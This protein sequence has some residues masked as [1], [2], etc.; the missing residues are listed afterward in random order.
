MRLTR[1]LATIALLAAASCETET[2]SMVVVDNDYP[3]VSDGGDATQEMTVFKVWWTTTLLPDPVAP[4]NE[5]EPERTVLN[6]DFAYAVVAPGWAPS[7]P[8][9]P[10]IFI[11][12]KSVG[13]L[14]VA[15]GDT[16]HIH[17]SDDLFVGNCAANKPLSQED[18][19]FISQ[20]IFPAEFAGATYDAK[21][22]TATPRTLRADAN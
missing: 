11:P 8:T 16:L 12:M 17:V 20:R 7:S 2:P 18:A 14:S 21:S 4:G 10:R 3:V 5:G 13:P 19:D 22:C 6:T 9:P 15:R 1:K